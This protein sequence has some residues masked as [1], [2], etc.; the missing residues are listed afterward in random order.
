MFL[1]INVVIKK[2]PYSTKIKYIFSIHFQYEHIFGIPQSHV[3]QKKIY[4]VEQ[5]NPDKDKYYL[6]APYPTLMQP[7]KKFSPKVSELLL[8]TQILI[9]NQLE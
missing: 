5:L 7:L 3:D 1:K 9:Y 2:S 6:R 8:A 4:N